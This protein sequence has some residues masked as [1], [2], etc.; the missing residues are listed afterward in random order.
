MAYIEF[1]YDI[2][3]SEVRPFAARVPPSIEVAFGALQ[4]RFFV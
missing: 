1:A 2:E 4:L 3:Y